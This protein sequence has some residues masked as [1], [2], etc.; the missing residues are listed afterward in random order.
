MS[1]GKKRRT[2]AQ[3]SSAC[4]RGVA[5]SMEERSRLMV[6]QLLLLSDAA[7]RAGEG[8]PDLGATGELR[9][10][11]LEVVEAAEAQARRWNDLARRLE[12]LAVEGPHLHLEDGGV[13]EAA[14]DHTADLDAAPLPL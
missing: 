8:W 3:L 9:T 5:V 11:L 12:A 1:R 13:I 2:A 14:D 6:N 7:Q 4:T 10:V